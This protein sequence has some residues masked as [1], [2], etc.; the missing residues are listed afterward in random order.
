MPAKAA[1][2]KAR[3]VAKAPVAKPRRGEGPVVA[4]PRPAKAFGA[5]RS[6]PRSPRP[7]AR[8]SVADTRIQTRTGARRRRSPSNVEVE[9]KHNCK[10]CARA[11]PQACLRRVCRRHVA[12]TPGGQ[13]R[14]GRGRQAGRTSTAGQGESRRIQDR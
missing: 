8:R 7:R 13:S 10:A 1:P 4:K 6:P 3:A 5:S 9:R 14:G 2:A 11:A 12:P